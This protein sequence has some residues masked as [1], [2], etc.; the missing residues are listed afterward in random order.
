MERI[1]DRKILQRTIAQAGIEQYFDTPELRFECFRYRKGEILA[2]PEDSDQ[3]L[4]IVIEGTLRVD[5][6]REDGSLYSLAFS[7][8]LRPGLPFLLGDMQFTPV[9]GEPPAFYAQAVTD[10][11]CVAL[12]LPVYRMRLREDTRFLNLLVEELSCKLYMLS[13]AA[14]QYTSLE[15][16]LLNYLRLSC[17]GG[18][19]RGIEHTAQRLHCSSRQLQ[20]VL[21]RLEAEQIVSHCGKGFYQLL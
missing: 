4:Q 18:A 21:N 15:E 8:L 5:F 19:L 20:R 13:G 6:L 16:R 7:D 2:R 10:I 3:Y 11:T 17:P 12:S 9:V 14:I 1:C